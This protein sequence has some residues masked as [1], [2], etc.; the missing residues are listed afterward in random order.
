LEKIFA[1]ILLIAL[2]PVLVIISILI[3][4]F[5]GSPILFKHNRCGY[6]FNEFEIYKFRTMHSNKGSELTNYNDKRITR[7]GQLLRKYKL[8]ELPQLM[9]ILKGDM[10]FIGPRPE[11]VRIVKKNPKDFSYLKFIKPGMSDINSIIFRDESKLFEKIDINK[12]ENEILPLKNH[13]TLITNQKQR[14]IQKSML[15]FLSIISIIHHKL[16]LRIISKFFLPY[17]E[18]EFRIKL[19]NLLSVKIF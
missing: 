18:T 3:I 11:I 8:D 5:S 13:L 10:E 4:I 19:N 16:S 1:F 9:N 2:S 14:M 15:F 7:I 17:D 6:K 12:Y